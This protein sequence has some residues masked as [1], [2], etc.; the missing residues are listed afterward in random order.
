MCADNFITYSIILSKVALTLLK[1]FTEQLRD[2]DEKVL[3]SLDSIENTVENSLNKNKTQNEITIYLFLTYKCI[4]TDCTFYLSYVIS[5]NTITIIITK[6]NIYNTQCY[7]KH[8]NNHSNVKK[9][10]SNAG[11]FFFFA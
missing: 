4:F 7:N 1:T 11:F 10:T 6:C 5:N 2:V 9:K 8:H 3:S